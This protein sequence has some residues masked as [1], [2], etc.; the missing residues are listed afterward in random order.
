MNEQHKHKSKT[1]G[2]GRF[3]KKRVVNCRCNHPGCGREVL[4]TN[5]KGWKEDIYRNVYGAESIVYCQFHRSIYDADGRVEAERIV[6]SVRIL[7]PG[8]ALHIKTDD[9]MARGRI[10]RAARTLNVKVSV[11]KKE[12]YLI[13][14]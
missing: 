4:M 6:R 7:M 8:Q 5:K 13:A 2:G 1:G 12:L 14:V 9:Q 10:I 11:L 3:G